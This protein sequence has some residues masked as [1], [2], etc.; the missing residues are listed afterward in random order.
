MN[1]SELPWEDMHHRSSFLSKP[2]SLEVKPK[3]VYLDD[4]MER[5]QCTVQTH[6][7]LLEG[8]LENISKTIPINISI[9]SDI[10]ENINIGSNCS[11][12]EIT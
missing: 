3:N 10:I 1:I 2:D 7:V 11:P 12:K 8:D 4:D 6:N 5:C 9:Q